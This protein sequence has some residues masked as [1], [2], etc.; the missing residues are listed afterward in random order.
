[1][2]L[3]IP[4]CAPHLICGYPNARAL[5]LREAF[6]TDCLT[7]VLKPWDPHNSLFR[8]VME[9]SMVAHL[10][11]IVSVFSF[12]G[13]VVVVMVYLP[14]QF[15]LRVLPGFLPIE[16]SVYHPFTSLGPWQVP[17]DLAALHFIVDVS[18]ELVMAIGWGFVVRV[19]T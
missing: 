2:S 4:V 12:I 5:Q 11:R 1:M 7:N 19:G 9:V 15:L 6:H 8:M 13:S 17:L 18:G 14:A 3:C 16:I 10:R